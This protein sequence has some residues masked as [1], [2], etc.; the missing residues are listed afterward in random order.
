MRTTL[1]AAALAA[2]A[3]LAFAQTAAPNEPPAV[4]QIGHEAIK[5]GKG[6]AHRKVEQDFANT[7]RKNKYPFHYLALSSQS[8]PNEVLFVHPFVR[9]DGG[10]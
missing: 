1:I 8:G 6:A 4:I 9:S 7:F 3:P 5:E 10:R 2:C